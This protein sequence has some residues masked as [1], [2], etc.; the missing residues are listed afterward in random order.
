MITVP[1][2]LFEDDTLQI[3]QRW[4]HAL[5]TLAERHEFL[6]DELLGKAGIEQPSFQMGACS[7]YRRRA[8]A[9]DG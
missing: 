7:T 3:A 5:I 6:C 9:R 4:R 8:F 1:Q 2:F